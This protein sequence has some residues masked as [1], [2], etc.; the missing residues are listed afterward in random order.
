[1][2]FKKIEMKVSQVA[3]DV[4]ASNVAIADLRAEVEDNNKV[5]DA[6]LTSIENTFNALA[7]KEDL[8]KVVEEM[9]KDDNRRVRECTAVHTSIYNDIDSFKSEVKAERAEYS[10]MIDS[11]FREYEIAVEKIVE[12]KV[13]TVVPMEVHEANGATVSVMG[14]LET[15]LQAALDQHGIVTNRRQL[16]G[17]ID[18]RV[19]GAVLEPGFYG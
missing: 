6:R 2:R 7:T 12:E 5:V 3:S 14:R 4:T 18:M 19:D 13:Q 1:M 17:V 10:E 11:R 9:K 8:K 16:A 15:M